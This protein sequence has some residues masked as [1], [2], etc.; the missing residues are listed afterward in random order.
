MSPEHL[1]VLFD[2]TAIP[3]DRG[4]VGR[5]VENVVVELVRSGVPLAVVCQPR[6]RAVFEAAGVTRVLEIAPWGGRASGRL[7]WEQLVLP[8]LARRAGAAVIHSPHYTFPLLTRRRRVVTVHDLTFFSAPELHGRVKRVFFR[9][10]IRAAKLFG[11][12]VVTPS[13]TTADEYLRVTRADPAQ[14]V[15]APLGYDTEIFHPPTA[16]E[17][18]RFADG[19]DPRPAAG[20]IAFLGTVEPRKNVTALVEGYVEAMRARPLGARPALLLAGGSGWDA[21][22]PVAVARAVAAGFDVRMLGYLP[23]DELR[24]LLGGSVLTAYP[25]LGEGF[26]LPVLEAMACGSC[27]LTTRRLSL[28][29]VGGDAVSYTDIDSASIAEALS[30]LVDH[31][32]ERARLSSA[33]RQRAAQ[34]TWAACA[35]RHREAYELALAGSG[36]K[37]GTL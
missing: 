27:V 13:R 10:W 7:V 29:E 12:T 2:A 30:A 11:V 6:D 19:L 31:P 5:Y 14:V 24:S 21:S 36:P 33:G 25:S 22:A 20:W 4:G 34:F 37:R 28:P 16:A 18:E 23:L 26:G 3:A 1:R 35:A 32:A 15:A 8:G 17:I 9:T